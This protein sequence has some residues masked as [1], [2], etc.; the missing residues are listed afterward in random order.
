[1]AMKD[2]CICRLPHDIHTVNVALASRSS[3]AL[4]ESAELSEGKCETLIAVDSLNA[5]GDMGRP[6]EE[7]GSL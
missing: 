2:D 1:M 6:K 3:G 7:K 4:H 5:E